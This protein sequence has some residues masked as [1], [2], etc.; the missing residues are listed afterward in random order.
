MSGP[1]SISPRQALAGAVRRR[2]RRRHHRARYPAAAHAARD[3]DRRD[4]R[5][6]RRRAARPVAQSARRAGAVRRAAGRLGRRIVHDRVWP[7]RRDLVRG[8][9]RRHCRR[10]GFGRRAGGD[11]RT[12]RQPDRDAAGGTCVRE[13][14]RRGHR[15]DPQSRADALCRARSRVL[16]AR[17]AGGPQHRSSADRRA[18]P[19]G[20]LDPAGA[21]RAR[22][23][24]AD[25][26][27]GRRGLARRRPQPHPHDGGDRHGARRRRRGGG[28]G[29]DRLHRAGGAA[30][31]AAMGRLR[32]GAACACPP[33]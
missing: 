6:V 30:S 32:S 2:G 22:L 5:A 7:R 15:A 28:C 1:A 11:R 10:A 17:L 13:L 26:R 20:E 3:P 16:A 12:A 9:D 27:R 29:F 18:V 4:I 21:Q 8:A 19:A 25:A 31:G 33:R 14:R 23:S 24:R